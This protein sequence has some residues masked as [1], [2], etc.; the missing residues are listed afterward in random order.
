MQLT[1][2]VMFSDAHHSLMD[3]ANSFRMGFMLPLLKTAIAPRLP[4]NQA[5]S[6]PFSCF[7]KSPETFL[8]DLQFLP[9]GTSRLLP[10][11]QYLKQMLLG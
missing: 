2:K 8:N 7:Q 5:T 9:G 4:I 3:A 10:C 1:D 6:F 11:I